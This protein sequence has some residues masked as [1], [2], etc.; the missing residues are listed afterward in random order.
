[1]KDK[2]S[3]KRRGGAKLSGRKTESDYNSK[4]VLQALKASSHP[5]D[6]DLNFKNPIQ[7][8]IVELGSKLFF[9]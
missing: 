9:L 2:R 7:F 3:Y 6:Q 5:S 1:M 8:L 4:L